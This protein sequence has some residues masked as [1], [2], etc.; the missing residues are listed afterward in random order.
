MCPFFPKELN[1][2]YNW[3]IYSCHKKERNCFFSILNINWKLWWQK[4]KN[5][6]KIK[7]HIYNESVMYYKGPF[8]CLWTFY[9][10]V[11][12]FHF[13]HYGYEML[14]IFCCY[15]F[16]Y[17]TFYLFNLTTPQVGKR[18]LWN[19]TLKLFFCS[20]LPFS[21]YFVWVWVFGRIYNSFSFVYHRDIYCRLFIY[22]FHFFVLLFLLSLQKSI[23]V[24]S[25][26]YWFVV[27]LV[28]VT[29]SRR[30][31]DVKCQTFV[32]EIDVRTYVSHCV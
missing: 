20:I 18:N 8:F 25:F 4:L 21:L 32:F 14:L 17:I 7:G 6:R 9:F 31:H 1:I 15:Y 16:I 12:C 30:G 13:H 23:V 2:L 11:I 3:V 5:Q 22:L 19:F 27:I 28:L 10:S 29:D 26:F 24:L